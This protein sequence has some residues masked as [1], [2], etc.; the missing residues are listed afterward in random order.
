MQKIKFA[1]VLIAGVAIGALLTWIL[2]VTGLDWAVTVW[3][4]KHPVWI[5]AATPFV[6]AGMI[7]PVVLLIRYT[8]GTL[9]EH[10]K[11]VWFTFLLAYLLSTLLKVFTNRVDMEPFEPLAAVDFSNAFRFGFYQGNSWWE[12]LSEG[13]PSGH[14]MVTA[15]MAIA[16]HPLIK[17]PFWR[18]ANAIYAVLMPF[19]VVTAFHWMSDVVA[20][21]IPGL[22]IGY[23]MRYFYFRHEPNL[24]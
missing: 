7:V 5:Y 10:K 15:A 21:L 17:N 20:G 4:S 23:G 9:P 14:T 24:M 3:F 11:L 13:W 16:I 1:F 22:I 6:L 8:I 12:S 2:V 19:A 18:Y